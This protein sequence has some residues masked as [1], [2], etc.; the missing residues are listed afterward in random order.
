[1][2]SCPYLAVGHGLV[3]AARQ[4]QAPSD[5]LDGLLSLVA[6]LPLADWRLAFLLAALAMASVMD[7]RSIRISEGVYLFALTGWIRFGGPVG[8]LGGVTG[9]VGAVS[10]GLGLR[11]YS[12]HRLGREGFSEADVFSGGLVGLYLGLGGYLSALTYGVWI[13]TALWKTGLNRRARGSGAIVFL[14]ALTAG[15]VLASQI[16]VSILI[17]TAAEMFSA[18]L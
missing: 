13:L 12:H 9:M 6:M 10:L 14:P 3:G 18:R 15:A 5:P 1:M 17:R 2:N 7:L 8:R 4:F 11:L 16:P